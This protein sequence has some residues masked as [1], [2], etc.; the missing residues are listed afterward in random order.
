MR[1]PWWR[2]WPPGRTRTIWLRPATLST[3]RQSPILAA[4]LRRP[5]ALGLLQPRHHPGDDL[6]REVLE[7]GRRRVDRLARK[8][9]PP[10]DVDHRSAAGEVDEALHRRSTVEGLDMAL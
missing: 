6:G 3:D 2:P 5:V 7:P 8:Q 1:R 9:R 4:P 10:V